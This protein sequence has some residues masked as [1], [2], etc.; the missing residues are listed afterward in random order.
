MGRQTCALQ[1]NNPQCDYP[2]WMD[3]TKGIDL[4]EFS[5]INYLS[6]SGMSLKPVVLNLF[7]LGD[8]LK[9]Q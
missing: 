1:T 2:R 6:D 3:Q 7:I 4:K 9:C 8:L 5:P